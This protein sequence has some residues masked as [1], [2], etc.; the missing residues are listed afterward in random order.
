V[1]AKFCTGC[2]CDAQRDGYECFACAGLST[3]EN[4]AAGNNF[5]ITI[6]EGGASPSKMNRVS[7]GI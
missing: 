3:D 6:L 4:N 7:D 1:T 2:Q 5:L